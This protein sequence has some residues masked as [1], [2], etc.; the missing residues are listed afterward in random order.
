MVGVGVPAT[1]CRKT[2]RRSC[3]LLIPVA[4]VVLSALLRPHSWAAEVA[5]LQ[6]AGRSDLSFEAA[7]QAALR[8][9]VRRGAGV[10]LSSHT[11][12]SDF[13]LVRDS[14]YSRAAGYVRDYEVVSREMEFGD[15]YLV[16]LRAE[17][18][19]ARIEDDLLAVRNLI[20]TVGR[21]RF[22]VTVQARQDSPDGLAAWVENAVYGYL[23]EN[24]FS[25]LHA[26]ARR[27]SLERQYNRAMASQDLRKARQLLLQMGAPYGIEIIAFGQISRDTAYGQRLNTANVELSATVVYSDTGDLLA[28]ESAAGRGSSSEQN[29]LR[30]AASAAVAA[31]FPQLFEGVLEHWLED[32]DVGSAITVT[33]YDASCSK[34][35]ELARQARMRE[36]VSKVT[37]V[38]APDGGIAVL[39]VLGRLDAEQVANEI[40]RWS[41][42]G[43]SASI[44]GPTLVTAQPLQLGRKAPTGERIP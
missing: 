19:R 21:P 22:S 3:A 5:R 39:R 42:G 37:I 14:I 6:C 23:D 28:S 15:T 9:A 2:V 27:R 34:V 8:E 36:E 41:G 43:L 12:A 29:G 25:A 1:T 13:A 18:V 31:I 30:L 20:E 17:V 38:E 33:V 44:E 11:E 24:G 7:T 16:K 40:P 26:G 10:V 32:L 35:S 4:S